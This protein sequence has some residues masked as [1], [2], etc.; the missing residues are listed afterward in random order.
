MPGKAICHAAD[1]PVLAIDEVCHVGEC[2]AL[3]V[4][5]TP[6]LAE[7]AAALVHLDLEELP[8]SLD[9]EV[10][11]APGAPTEQNGKRQSRTFAKG[12]PISRGADAVAVV[13]G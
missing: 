2:I 8:A 4:A 9:I 11:L 5:E 13:S 12:A 7:D 6:S 3:V 10:A 1:P